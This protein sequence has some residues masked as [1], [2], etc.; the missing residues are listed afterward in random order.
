MKIELASAILRDKNNLDPTTEAL[1][2]LIEYYH[3]LHCEA[4]SKITQQI[5]EMQQTL[6]RVKYKPDGTLR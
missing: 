2:A 4:I 3:S 6:E 1:Y 5:F